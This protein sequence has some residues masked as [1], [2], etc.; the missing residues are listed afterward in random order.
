LP[1]EGVVIGEHRA[2]KSSLDSP[3]RV[4][5][6]IT[7]MQ[8]DDTFV[9]DVSLDLA[10][11]WNDSSLAS[12]TEADSQDSPHCAL[13]V[14]GMTL[15]T[16]HTE[17]P[18]F[19]G[20][21]ADRNL[22]TSEWS[23]SQIYA[24][25][26]VSGHEALPSR[27]DIYLYAEDSEWRDHSTIVVRGDAESGSVEGGLALS[28]TASEMTSMTSDI[29]A[30]AS[31][32]SS[33]LSGSPRRYSPMGCP[34]SSGGGRGRTSTEPSQIQPRCFVPILGLRGRR[35]TAGTIKDCSRCGSAYTG[36]GEVCADCRKLGKR[37]SSRQ[38]CGCAHFFHGFSGTC[39]DCEHLA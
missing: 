6:D 25:I 23:S 32:A 16:L 15:D 26:D 20:A 24:A 37:G 31:V 4:T 36:F 11:L 17:V 1:D 34:R 18:Y 33:T 13:L 35:G 39:S 3:T 14:R 12:Y 8:E 10:H 27:D 29:N 19:G 21:L 5:I 22:A 7:E 2:R 28:E 38:C 30:K 9:S